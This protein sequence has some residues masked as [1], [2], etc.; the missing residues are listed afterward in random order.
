MLKTSIPDVESRRTD[1]AE[2]IAREYNVTAILKGPWTVIANPQGDV[3]INPTGS[4]SLGTAGTG[5]VLAGMLGG[6]LA[7]RMSPW[8]AAAAG[9]YLHG[10]AGERAARRLGPDGLMAG[11]ILLEIPKVLRRVR[12]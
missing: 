2:H 1:V 11:D 9:V 12:G 10:L 4:R 3:R 8:D 7:Q 6:F 5:D